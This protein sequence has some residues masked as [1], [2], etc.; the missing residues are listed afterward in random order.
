VY[1]KLWVEL[2]ITDWFRTFE[3]QNELYNQ[4][5]YGNAWSVVTWA[6]WGYSYHNY[7]LWFDVSS[8]SEDWRRLNYNIDWN[9]IWKIW[10]DAWFEWWWDWKWKMD[11]PHFQE[12]YQYTTT[13]LLKFVQNWKID[14]E[15]YIEW[16]ALFEIE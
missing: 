7:W 4:W 12:T 13:E 11:R 9:A 2:F 1:K 14:S 10:K 5:R 16:Y 15:W 8:L 3:E 6:K